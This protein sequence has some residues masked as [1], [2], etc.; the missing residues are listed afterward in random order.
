[1]AFRDQVESFGEVTS[2]MSVARARAIAGA[3][4]GVSIAADKQTEGR[5][6]R[7]RN[8]YSP[9]GGL[10]LTTVLRPSEPLERLP[11]LAIVA[12]LAVRAAC[13]ESGAEGA[14]LKW[15]NDVIVGRKKL[16][17][18][19]LETLTESA[20]ETAVL[21][22]IGVNLEERGRVD[23]SDEL[24]LRFIGL[25]DLVE[26]DPDPN[27]VAER[28]L[29]A[30]EARYRAWQGGRWDELRSEFDRHHALRGQSIRAELGER[31]LQGRAGDLDEAGALQIE[32]KNGL[33]RVHSGEV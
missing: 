26:G 3:P 9:S 18:I 10:Y 17:G 2:T 15:P 25:G 23:L 6:R 8:W 24:A 16:A 13:V 20:G 33:E 27:G 19:L 30:L 28:I 22:G 31:S 7:G 14:R 12:G 32:T 21:V 1:M 5:G 29:T 4:E 11:Q